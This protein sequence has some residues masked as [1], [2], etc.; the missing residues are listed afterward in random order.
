M[1]G[2]AASFGMEVRKDLLALT[3]RGAAGGTASKP[4]SRLSR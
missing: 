3:M 4:S 1:R 2:R